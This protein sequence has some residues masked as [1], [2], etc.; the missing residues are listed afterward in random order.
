[1]E[2]FRKRATSAGFWANYPNHDQ[3][4][5]EIKSRIVKQKCSASFFVSKI[6]LEFLWEIVF[7]RRNSF[8]KYSPPL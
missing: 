8:Q 3:L 1:M 7:F 2:I 6:Y 5:I 4:F